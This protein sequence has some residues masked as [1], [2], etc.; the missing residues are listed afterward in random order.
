MLRSLWRFCVSLVHMIFKSIRQVTVGLKS[1]WWGLTGTHQ[2]SN[3][4]NF[5][6]GQE[7]MLLRRLRSKREAF[8]TCRITT[9][10]NWNCCFLNSRSIK[11]TVTLLYVN[12]LNSKKKN[13]TNPFHCK[14]NWDWLRVEHFGEN[15]LQMNKTAQW[16]N[17]LQKNTAKL[18]LRSSFLFLFFIF[19]V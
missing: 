14:L 7:G 4:N 1:Y 11:C 10:L 19:W 9:R 2:F 15:V 12:Y 17:I 8:S 16:N 6:S 13:K 5:K 3:T 18:T